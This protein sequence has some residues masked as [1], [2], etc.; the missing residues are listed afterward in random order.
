MRRNQRKKETTFIG[1]KK[2]CFLLFGFI[3]GTMRSEASVRIFGMV[4]WGASWSE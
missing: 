4:A 3:N 1:W 2:Y